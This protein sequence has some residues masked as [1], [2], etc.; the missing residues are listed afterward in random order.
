MALKIKHVADIMDGEVVV[1]PQSRAA[2]LAAVLTNVDDANEGD[3]GPNWIL[4]LMI[5]E[6]HAARE[7]QIEL[8]EILNR[9]EYKNST[10]TPVF[11]RKP[12]QTVVDLQLAIFRDKMF[13]V[14]PALRNTSMQEEAALRTKRQVYA[15][16]A[17]VA[18]LKSYVA[19]VEAAIAYQ[20]GPKREPIPEDVKMLVWS[21]DG[22]ACTRC[23]SKSNLHFDHIIP[24]AKGGSSTAENIQILCQPCNLRKSDKIAF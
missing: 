15:H 18:S 12:V 23:G 3:R 5:G 4:T 24:V 21:R 19:N 6:G 13:S 11:L 7:V 22:G 8:P 2:D 1:S 17:E 16:D 14:E 10:A 9:Q 20:A